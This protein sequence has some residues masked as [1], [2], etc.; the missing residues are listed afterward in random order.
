MLHGVTALMAAAKGGHAGVA[1]LLGC[2]ASVHVVDVN[3]ASALH[4]AAAGGHAAYACLLLQAGADVNSR[5]WAKRL[6]PLHLA[7]C[8]RDGETIRALA[9]AGADL[10]A[11]DADGLTPRQL[12]QQGSP[13]ALL[14]HRLEMKAKLGEPGAGQ[15]RL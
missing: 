4:W 5:E 11:W 1:K 6:T 8:T 2:G 10:A 14:M 13:T 15:C 12:A 9:E 7:V 3:G